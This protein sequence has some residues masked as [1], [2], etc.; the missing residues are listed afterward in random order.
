M[1]NLLLT[2]EERKRFC[3]YIRTCINSDKQIVEQMQRLG[4]P[5]A[6]IQ[7]TDLELLAFEIVLKKLESV[8]DCKL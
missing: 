1:S 3:E 2:P 8:E 4:V 7:K 6:M 5:S